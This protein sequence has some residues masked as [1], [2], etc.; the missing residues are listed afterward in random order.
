MIE[1]RRIQV[2]ADGPLRLSG[3][4]IRWRDR[5]T[6][7]DGLVERFLPG[8]FGPLEG[9]DVILNLSHDRRS[10]IARTGAAGGLK[11]WE[12]SEGIRFTA[13]LPRTQRAR[14]AIELVRSGVLGGC[15]VEFSVSEDSVSGG[16]RTISKAR[17]SGFALVDRPAYSQSVVESRQRP[18]R[19]RVRSKFRSGRRL[20]CRCAQDCD[21]VEF[22]AEAIKSMAGEGI[23]SVLGNYSRVLGRGTVSKSGDVKIE[24]D[25]TSRVG[26]EAIEAAAAAPLIVRP[27]ADREKSDFEVIEGPDGS[28]TEKWKRVS[29]RALILV[30]TDQIGGWSTAEIDDSDSAQRWTNLR[31]RALLA[32][33]R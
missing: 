20:E 14:D 31:R 27:F 13:D 17:L 11:V 10:P 7:G 24:F 25:P 4:L 23:L 26:L 5:A 3:W 19:G 1:T 18:R 8:C 15:S 30:A 32:A 22:E 9:A 28:K 21:H 2:A 16:V 12:T 29:L 33:V 6:I